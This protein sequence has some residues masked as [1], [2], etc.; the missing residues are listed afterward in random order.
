MLGLDV[1]A[2]EVVESENCVL[3]TVRCEESQVRNVSPGVRSIGNRSNPTTADNGRLR[4]FRVDLR[5]CNNQHVQYATLDELGKEMVPT[6][7]ADLKLA[8][9]PKPEPASIIVIILNPAF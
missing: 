9:V 2:L 8:E 1:V 6:P 5:F 4:L 3:A 7:E